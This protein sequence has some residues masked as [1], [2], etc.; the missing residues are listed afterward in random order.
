MFY[1]YL[2]IP[3]F[4]PIPLTYE[5]ALVVALVVVTVVSFLHCAVQGLR[6]K[7]NEGLGFL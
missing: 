6:L 7:K 5:F 2:R 3:A 1:T 4:L